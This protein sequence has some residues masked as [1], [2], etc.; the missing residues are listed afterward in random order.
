VGPGCSL[1]GRIH[2]ENS[3]LWE[4]VQVGNGSMIKDALVGA[5]CRLGQEVRVEPG[6]VI[7]SGCLLDD[8]TGIARNTRV[9]SSRNGVMQVEQ[10]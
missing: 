7:A 2:L 9:F 4:N 10:G 6:A 5:E 3:V 1:E 8:G